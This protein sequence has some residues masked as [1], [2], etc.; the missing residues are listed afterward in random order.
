MLASG[1][2]VGQEKQCCLSE[3]HPDPSCVVSVSS[4]Q[5]SVNAAGA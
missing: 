1:A 3:L 4:R 5:L 2:F